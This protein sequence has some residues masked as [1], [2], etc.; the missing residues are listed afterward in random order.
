MLNTEIVSKIES[1]VSQKPRSVNEIA[2]HLKRNWRTADRYVEEIKTNFGTINTR[3]FRE[4][5]RGALKIVYWSNPDNISQTV[6]QERLEKE[7]F[8]A[9]RKE[10]FS[11][12][13]IYEQVL[14]KNKRALVEKV[15]DSNKSLIE[16]SELLNSTKKQLL[17]FSGNLSLI[18]MHNKDFDILSILEKLVKNNIHIKII[19]RVDFIGRNNIEKILALNFKCGKE[20]IE[21]RH[22]EHP[23]RAYI[24]DNKI[25]RLKEVK[26][27]T[28]KFNELDKKIYIFYTIKDKEWGEWLSK[29]FWK[30]F[31][32]SIDARK[33]I[34]EL[35]KIKIN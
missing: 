29:M 25:I 3:V 12:F 15:E 17:L 35:N 30:I 5:T 18:N 7:I 19:C 23:I 11:A 8:L 27:P 13:D 4:G 32:S 6:R 2:F 34:E 9:K 20:L 21:I 10:D 22:N 1:F 14:D 24:I 26:E 28:G 16:L 31:N 33:R